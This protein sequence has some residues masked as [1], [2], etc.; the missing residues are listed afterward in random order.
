[1]DSFEVKI[2]NMNSV[3]LIVL[4]G[5]GI[6]PLS[7]GNAIS[8]ANTPFFNSLIEN[9][10]HG[11][12]SASG[13]S[14]GLPRGEDGNT[15]TGHL[16]LGA[17]YIVPQDIQRINFAIGNGS[18]YKNQA[19][20][21]SLNHARKYESNFHLLGLIGSGGVHSNIE[22][23]LALLQFIKEQD[24]KRVYLHLITDGRDS[25]PK[26]ALLFLSQISNFLENIKF[27]KIATIMGR[28]YAMDR[29]KRWG[30]TEMAYIALTEDNVKSE[31]SVEDVINNSYKRGITDEF[32]VPTAISENGKTLPRIK[33]RDSVIFFNYRIDR[34]RQL[35][36]AFILQDFE[37][38][39]NNPDFDPY[40]VKYFKKHE[41]AFS[42]YQR[43]FI[44]NVFLEHLFF[45]TM[46]EYSQAFHTSE[47]AFPPHIVAK[48]LGNIIEESGLS[49]L[50]MS[51]S[52]KERFVTYYF[53][54][55]REVP[56][57]NQE[58]IIIPSPNVATYDLAPQMS[59]NPLTDELV[60]KIEE[61]R[62][63]FIVVNFA[64]ADMVAHTG[65][66]VPTIKACETLDNC[67]SR[68]LPVAVK[69]GHTVIITADH[70]NAEEMLNLNS[71]G[72]NTEHST[73]PVPVIVASENLAGKNISIP[74][75]ILA[76]IAPTVLAL[77]HLGIPPSMTGRNLLENI[78]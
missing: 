48:P 60:K 4:D 55:Q 50:H 19:F 35:T 22:H 34:P 2:F 1:M 25:P 61:G 21:D 44:R 71:G 53:N 59:A 77:L 54:G 65:N 63:H 64:N 31:A 45:V 32:V 62:H 17:G 49:Q 8:E 16:N 57:V 69:N 9:Y 3:I 7:P 10:P 26:S 40:T 58:N 76:D 51:E 29:D 18:F 11:Q 70:G 68:I 52:E 78:I 67:L 39:S 14:V 56:F 74:S 30:R 43:P 28:F 27:G 5:W 6:A 73:N 66:I 20:L 72:I 24:F 33:S 23:L 41:V 36:K 75:G 42:D 15:E 46:T 12:L 37:S 47:V 38:M 13:E